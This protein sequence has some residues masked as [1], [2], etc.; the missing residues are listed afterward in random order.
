MILVKKIKLLGGAL[1]LSL[2]SVTLKAQT[3]QK[4]FFQDSISE[5]KLVVLKKEFGTNKTIIKE[6]ET[7]IL[8]AL[9]FYPEL[10]NTEIEFRIKKTKTPLTSKPSFTSMFVSA[11]KRKYYVTISSQSI[12]ALEPILFRNLNFNAQIGVLGH[13]LAHIAQYNHSGFGKM[14]H[15]VEIELFSKNKVDRFEHNT[16]MSCINHGL[17]YQLL[18]WSKS[19]REKLCNQNWRGANNVCSDSKKE[20]YMNPESIIKTIEELSIYNHKE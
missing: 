13:E 19:V 3:I 11:K 1:L 10:K 7:Q 12:E 6:Y 5:E 9:S 8:L 15:I 20:R 4:Q 16:D 14:L 2:V 18:D 17:G